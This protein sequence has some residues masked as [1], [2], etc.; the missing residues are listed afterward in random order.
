LIGDRVLPSLPVLAEEAA[1]AVLSTLQA[2]GEPLR[3]ESRL[4]DEFGGLRSLLVW[5]PSRIEREATPSPL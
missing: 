4:V 1:G 5:I 3:V 2:R